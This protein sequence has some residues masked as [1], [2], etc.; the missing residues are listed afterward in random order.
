MNT[1]RGTAVL[2]LDGRELTA[3]ANL[4]KD[5]TGSWS[6]TLSFPASARTPELL[7]LRH[8]QLRVDGL[9][10]KFDR[11]DTSDWVGSPNGQLQI[12]IMGNG[13]APF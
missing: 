1:H 7:N 6:G 8:G 5:S 11:L 3:V 12:K 2:L 10:G 9:D 13:E 4:S